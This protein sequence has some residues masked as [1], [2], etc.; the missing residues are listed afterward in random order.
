MA[1]S[2]PDPIIIHPQTLPH[3]QTFILLHGRGSSASKF[4]PPLLASPIVIAGSESEKTLPDIFPHAKFVF[5]TA[6]RRRATLYKRSV[7]N[8]WF[9]CWEIAA[10]GER[11]ELQ[12]DGLRESTGYIHGVIREEARVLGGTENIILGGLS[13]GCAA[14]VVALLLW[15]GEGALGGFV[16]MCGRLPFRRQLEDVV[17]GV[18]GDGD[19]VDGED[20][21]PFAD[22]DD[23]DEDDGAHTGV[24]GAV[25]YLREELDI[26]PDIPTK[27][28]FQQTPIFLGH[29][30]LD[31]KVPVTLGEE[32]A[33]CLDSM[34]AEVVWRKYDDLGHWYSPAMLGDFVSFA[35]EHMCK[36]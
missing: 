13:Q 33:T 27:L 18:Y 19:E 6:S 2:Y 15:D 11:E 17:R 4:A 25:A 5:L 8:Q 3:K 34:G 32:M 9:D 14:S 30:S 26:P 35:R 21:N 7:I 24:K 16:G 31:E 23:E 10:Q 36:E 22:E 1:A 20:F 29:G 12:V 28:S